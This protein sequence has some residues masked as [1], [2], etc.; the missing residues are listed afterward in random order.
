MNWPSLWVWKLTFR[1]LS[2]RYSLW[3][4]ANARNVSFQTQRCLIS[5]S[6]TQLKIPNFGLVTLYHRRSTTVSSESTPFISSY[7][8]SLNV[9]SLEPIETLLQGTGF[10]MGTE[11]ACRLLHSIL[12][13]ALNPLFPTNDK[14]QIFLII[15]S[16]NQTSR[17][18]EKRKWSLSWQCWTFY[19]N[20]YISHCRYKRKLAYYTSDWLSSVD[21][22]YSEI[23]APGYKLIQRKEKT[24]RKQTIVAWGAWSE[25]RHRPIS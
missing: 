12:F 2:F 25:D 17:T 7:F 22:A 16:L 6:S 3:R 20:D 14:P 1:A 23:L 9:K 10:E 15:S 19:F 21:C 8:Y 18:R 5:W 4:G 13:F 24:K 11:R